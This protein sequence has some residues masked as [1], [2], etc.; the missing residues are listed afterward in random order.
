MT[1]ETMTDLGRTELPECEC[2]LYQFREDGR[3]HEFLVPQHQIGAMFSCL[4][5]HD[6][7][8]EVRCYPDP[9]DMLLHPMR[10]GMEIYKHVDFAAIDRAL[11]ASLNERQ[12][13]AFANVARIDMWFCCP[14]PEAREDAIRLLCHELQVIL[15]EAGL[16]PPDYAVPEKDDALA[17][18]LIAVLQAF[19]VTSSWHDRDGYDLDI[20]PFVLGRCLTKILDPG[21]GASGV[22]LLDVWR[23][24]SAISRA[25]MSNLRGREVAEAVKTMK[26]ASPYLP[27]KTVYERV[28]RERIQHK[29]TTTV[30]ATA[31]AKKVARHRKKFPED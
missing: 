4:S 19:E 24:R 9:R 13:W 26:T 17:R 23:T 2:V 10:R 8:K 5:L 18:W 21:H 1:I 22:D 27:D 29:E 3:K 28:A 25:H 15:C 12:R 16:H 30:T 14:D 7:T 11:S 20:A 6:P 31:V